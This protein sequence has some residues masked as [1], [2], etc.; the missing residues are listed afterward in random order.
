MQAAYAAAHDQHLAAC[1]GLGHGLGIPAEAGVGIDGALAHGEGGIDLH[2][3]IGAQLFK[4]GNIGGM[5]AETG[6]AAKA[7]DAA[8]DGVLLPVQCLIGEVGIGEAL[9]SQ[10]NKVGLACCQH[11]LAVL[12]AVEAAHHGYLGLGN[13]GLDLGGIL[14]VDA[15]GLQEGG[16]GLGLVA[17]P[18]KAVGHVDDVHETV[19]LAA[20][21]HRVIDGHAALHAVLGGEAQFND[22][23][24]ADTAAAGVNEHLGEAGAVFHRAAEFIGAVVRPRGNKLLHNK[25]VTAVDE[26][27]VEAAGL[28][29][30]GDVI[31]VVADLLHHRKIQ[32][33]DLHAVIADVTIGTPRGVGGIMLGAGALVAELKVAKCAVFLN[34]VGVLLDC[35]EVGALGLGEVHVVFVEQGST[36]LGV[37]G[38]LTCGHGG[39]AALGAVFH[40][41]VDILLHGR[42][43]EDGVGKHGGSGNKAVFID[44]A[45]DGDRVKE[46]GELRMHKG[47]LLHK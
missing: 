29:I 11:F 7:T 31:E 46:M 8:A 3:L 38:M 4:E 44:L 23:V 16:E 35:L 22:A 26:N 13:G 20:E 9:T 30:G 45:A 47:G 39:K 27:A 14:H 18:L 6:I 2:G 34:A 32:R 28:G 33:L 42:N 15:V 25:A 10:L 5:L 41:A 40:H 17:C 21:R 37:N 24:L 1:L 19:D 12:G 36:L 43:G